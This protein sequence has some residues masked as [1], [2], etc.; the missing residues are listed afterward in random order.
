LILS[1]VSKEPEGDLEDGPSP[2]EEPTTHPPSVNPAW[3]HLPPPPLDRDD[4]Q[5]DHR[6]KALPSELSGVRRRS[7]LLIGSAILAATTIATAAAILVVLSGESDL[8]RIS[9]QEN[10]ASVATTVPSATTVRT[11]I[12]TNA[13]PTSTTTIRPTTTTDP[14]RTTTP[15]TTTTVPRP[16][17]TGSRFTPGDTLTANSSNRDFYFTIETTRIFEAETFSSDTDPYLWLYDN[18]GALITSNDDG[19]NIGL[20][21]FISIQL[22]PGTYRLR[23]SV[24]CEG[25]NTWSGPSYTIETR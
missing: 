3:A 12:S 8:D 2:S 13:V 25:P 24:C 18:S 22:S 1:E 20:D 23:A 19:I 6:N 14:P 9:S 21:S 4:P 16:T 11:P 17:P 10:Q 15:I 7:K 5:K